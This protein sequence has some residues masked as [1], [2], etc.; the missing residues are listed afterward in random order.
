MFMKFKDV[1]V[2]TGDL[3]LLIESIKSKID[4]NVIKTWDYDEVENNK[5]VFYHIGE[6]YI[7]HVYFKYSLDRAKG[8]VNF[9]MVSDGDK[10]S[11]MKVPQLFI[12]MLETHFRDRIKIVL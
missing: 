1:T 10:F 5:V 9:R 2:A 7:E 12:N 4:S 11:E 3:D 8:V 6:Q